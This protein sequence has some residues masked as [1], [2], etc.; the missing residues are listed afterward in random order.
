VVVHN[1]AAGG[2]GFDIRDDD[3]RSREIIEA[4][5]EFFVRALR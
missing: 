1:H 2:H 3:D 5:L 4:A